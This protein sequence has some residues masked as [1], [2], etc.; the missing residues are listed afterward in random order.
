MFSGV[1]GS[2][3]GSG[4]G[5]VARGLT[6]A[7]D[8]IRGAD[9]CELGSIR[10][11]ARPR[12]DRCPRPHLLRARDRA[13]EARERREFTQLLTEP[14]RCV[15]LETGP[16]L[17]REVVRM[18]VVTLSLSELGRSRH[19]ARAPRLRTTR[20]PTLTIAPKYHI[21]SFKMTRRAASSNAETSARNSRARHPGTRPRE[22]SPHQ[23]TLQYRATWGGARRNA[24][25]K[26]G[27]HANTPHRARPPH[28]PHEPVHV[29]LRS[30][31]APLRSQFVFPTV[32]LALE[33][34]ARRAPERFRIVQY[35]V[36]KDHV[37]LVV[38][39]ADRR[40]LSSGLRGVA[41]RIARYVNDLLS[42]S[43]P[44]WAGRS[45]QRAL[46]TPREVRHALRYV[47]TNFRKHERH[48]SAAGV[49]PYSS[50]AWFDG[51]RE[52]SGSEGMPP[53]LAEPAPW[54]R[55]DLATSCRTFHA[56]TWLA[57]V[58][59]RRHGLLSLEERPVHA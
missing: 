57:R 58:G 35:S 26:P 52:R 9:P 6:L 8:D 22:S 36:Q 12:A 49:D 33:R 1:L 43:G 27:P 21:A 53:S 23:L 15:E 45:H 10:R 30:R 4:G 7:A 24:G 20:I 3:T 25:R 19:D 29:T 44:L 41:I 37:H 42:R 14:L 56:R 39:A 46:T 31:I 32:R 40:A 55:E 17:N 13:A 54:A 47:L 28:C 38:E 16:G 34:A 18:L 50:A 59:W 11:S 2:P 51:W 48:V 5:D